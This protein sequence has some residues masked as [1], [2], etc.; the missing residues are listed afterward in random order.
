MVTRE[1][2]KACIESFGDAETRRILTETMERFDDR[3]DELI[4]KANS[5]PIQCDLIPYFDEYYLLIDLM[6][7]SRRTDLNTLN[8]S[9]CDFK[10]DVGYYK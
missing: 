2:I 9:V 7:I 3:I 4:E 6:G 5:D 10:K 1:T 8:K